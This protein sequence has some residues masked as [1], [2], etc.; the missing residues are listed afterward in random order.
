MLERLG[1]TPAVNES[2]TMLGLPAPISREAYEQSAQVFFEKFNIP[3]LSITDTPLL[4]A[5]ATGVVSALSVDV[6]ADETAVAAVCDFLAISIADI[7]ALSERRTDRLLDVMVA[8]ATGPVEKLA[9]VASLVAGK[10][11]ERDDVT[12]RS[13]RTVTPGAWASMIR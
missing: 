4:A 2:F 9:Y 1:I 5:Y 12:A 6:G 11:Q 3:A 8:R 7:G 10:H 13:G